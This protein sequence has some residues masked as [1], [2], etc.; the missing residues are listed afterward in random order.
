MSCE[1]K[2]STEHLECRRVQDR[3]TGP[4]TNRS[5]GPTR[6]RLDVRKRNLLQSKNQ[7]EQTLNSAR[8]EV[9]KLYDEIAEHF[10]M[11]HNQLQAHPRHP[12]RL[13]QQCQEEINAKTAQIRE[14]NDKV[15]VLKNELLLVTKM[16]QTQ[17]ATADGSP[18]VPEQFIRPRNE[19]TVLQAEVPSPLQNVCGFPVTENQFAQLSDMEITT[20]MQNAV[21]ESNDAIKEA[22]QTLIDPRTTRNQRRKVHQAP[23]VK[24]QDQQIAE[25]IYSNQTSPRPV[26]SVTKAETPEQAKVHMMQSK[27]PNMNE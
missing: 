9:N 21:P 8:Q 25:S 15:A 26:V 19:Q 18:R 4:W 20:E 23:V 11:L 24:S 10:Q 14:L 13:V 5:L 12:A 6:A 3:S 1:K 7:K 22:G 2:K 16:I 27:T 17:A